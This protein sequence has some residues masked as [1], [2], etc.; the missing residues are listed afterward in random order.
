MDQI[1]YANGIPELHLSADQDLSTCPQGNV[2]FTANLSISSSDAIYTWTY[3]SQILQTGSASTFNLVVLNPGDLIVVSVQGTSDCNG[4]P[5]NAF[6]YVFDDCNPVALFDIYFYI[7]GYYLGNGVMTPVLKNCVPGYSIG[8]ICDS[9]NVELHQI[10]PPFSTVLSFTT[11][12]STFG[13]CRVEVPRAYAFGSYYVVLKTRNSLETW[14]SIPVSPQS[15]IYYFNS[16]ASAYGNNLCDLGDGNYAVWSGDLSNSSQQSK[17][18]GFINE[19]DLLKMETVSQSFNSG[20][21]REDITGDGV[22]ESADYS[23]LENNLRWSL[24]VV[25]P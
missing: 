9:V 8:Y 20:Y 25:R 21:L 14:S 1:I 6:D 24:H 2:S 7:Q 22:V 5:F 16:P 4:V 12:F 18:D 19:E 11:V 3:N 13:F 17:N 23:M 15:G 10:T